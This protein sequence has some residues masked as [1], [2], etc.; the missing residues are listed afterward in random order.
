MEEISSGEK[1]TREQEKGQQE[2]APREPGRLYRS[3]TNRVIGGVA[4]GIGEYLGIDPI[5]I[6]II[7]VILALFAGVGVVAYI[8]AWIIIP[9][10]LAGEEA[11]Q[12][13]EG[14]SSEAGLIVGLILVG[15]GA[16]FLLSNLNLIPPPLFAALRIIRLALWPITLILVGIIIIIVASRG[17]GVTISAKGKILRRSRT[18]RRI[19][20]VA[21]GLG[22]YLGIDSTLIRLAWVAFTILSPAAGIIAYIVAAIVIPEEPKA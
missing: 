22:E 20:G 14:F 9:E 1:E 6:R 18:N 13:P 11:P 12:A 16:W 21:G 5:I 4:G 2:E 8:L 3:R 10:R 17:R 7:W 15:L 19:A